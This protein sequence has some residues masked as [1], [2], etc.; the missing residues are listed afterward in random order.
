[1]KLFQVRM[2]LINFLLLLDFVLSKRLTNSHFAESFQASQQFCIEQIYK[3]AIEMRMN[4]LTLAY[5]TDSVKWQVCIDNLA[6][7][8]Y[9]KNINF[10]Q[11]QSRITEELNREK[12]DFTQRKTKKAEESYVDQLSSDIYKLQDE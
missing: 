5:K 3:E 1:M 9:L 7:L 2:A 11:I 4:V 6:I 12:F 10:N 8:S